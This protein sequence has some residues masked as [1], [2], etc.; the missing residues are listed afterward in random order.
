M[1]KYGTAFVPIRPDL[2]KFGSEL[3]KRIGAV[4]TP[5][6]A[7]KV[8]SRVGK[9]TG[10][11]LAKSMADRVKSLTPKGISDAVSS[12]SARVAAAG[13]RLGDSLSSAFGRAADLGRSVG[14]D[15][16]AINSRFRSAG[17]QLA[18]TLSRGFKSEAVT[19][20]VDGIK[21]FA[22]RA[23]SEATKAY[24][25][26]KKRG[27]E[28]AT[29]VVDGFRSGLGRLKGAFTSAARNLATVGA[30]ALIA[31]GGLA[32]SAI[33]SASDLSESLSKNAAVFGN[34]AS[35][36]E[37]FSKNSATSIGL[38]QTAAIDSVT[39]YGNLLQQVGG[40]SAQESAK[41]GQNLTTL[42]ADLASFYNTDTADVTTALNSALTGEFEP[43]KRFGVVVN[44]A[45]LKQKALEL[46]LHNGTGALDAQTKQ[47]AT[48]ALIYE[49]TT[50]AQGDFART[51]GGLANQQKILSSQFEN[52]KAT[53][54]ERLLPV[55][56][57]LVKWANENMPRALAFLEGAFDRIGP[58]VTTVIGWVS[59]LIEQFRGSGD[60]ISGLG[61]RAK[62]I[63]D[64]IRGAVVP[65][66]TEIVGY[67]VEHWPQISS[68]ISDVMNGIHEI[69]SAVIGLIDAIWTRWGDT[70]ITI[71]E[72][73]FGTLAGIIEPILGAIAGVIRAITAAINGD[74]SKAWEELK[75]ASARVTKAVRSVI[76]RGMT[77]VKAVIAT[78][79]REIV[80]FFKKLPG[81]IKGV[82]TGASK[83][84]YNIG[85]DIINGLWNG[86]KK[87][88]ENVSGWLSDRGGQIKNLKGP[89]EKDRV[90]LVDEGEAIMGGLGSGLQAGWRKVDGFLS[91]R[92]REI[93]IG[94]D[95]AGAGRSTA[96]TFQTGLSDSLAGV[97]R[98][99]DAAGRAISID[100]DLKSQ[101]QQ[102]IESLLD[103][104]REG[105]GEVTDWL[106]TR[107]DSF[108]S[109][110]RSSVDEPVVDRTQ[111]IVDGYR[112]AIAG[113]NLGDDIATG[114]QSIAAGY[115]DAIANAGAGFN[116][117]EDTR[118]IVQG[119]Q[120]ALAGIR[121]GD[122]ISDQ[123]V[124]GI[125]SARND[126]VGASSRGAKN[127]TGADGRPPQ[128]DNGNNSRLAENLTIHAFDADEAM[129]KLSQQQFQSARIG[130][131]Q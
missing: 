122:E 121:V 123:L 43:L 108:G 71:V 128:F 118:S 47:A 129:A 109:F 13:S 72:F 115:R 62:E 120:R 31:G 124:D 75:A 4:K 14:I 17:T 73:A 18:E 92:A 10:T 53:L 20:A 7:K 63:F 131:I 54:G 83:I 28:L 1:N 42:S 24:S 38:S 46:G 70:I 35:D 98:F 100:A 74:W 33:G 96:A 6:A 44:E 26:F 30:G 69:I 87:A 45:T 59:S 130:G 65:V 77:A 93:N 29:K 15:V 39:S 23:R 89:I 11:S 55:A 64:Q 34:Y 103:G 78:V 52:L 81:R 25:R 8:G 3:N 79:L 57:R 48:L 104:M 97:I 112:E 99:T 60:S 105:W 106:D 67:I 12:S 117:D 9:A 22:S 56:L 86:M 5:P 82:L 61:T 101:G 32:V 68:T 66:V 94:A 110:N 27:R 36:V 16:T 2:N 58:I 51:S 40:L 49:N 114:T 107:S 125:S 90:L 85:K 116:I 102:I 19:G 37:R 127:L 119:Y 80:A 91:T 50:N 113:I 21:S 95:L 84:L 126:L 76:Q 111:S 41:I 88:W